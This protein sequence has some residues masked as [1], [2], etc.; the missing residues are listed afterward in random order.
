MNRGGRSGETALALALEA[1]SRHEIPP[2]DLCLTL[3]REYRKIG[4]LAAA[5]RWALAVVDAGDDF[6]AWRSAAA[7]L[8][9]CAA[10]APPPRRTVRIAV[11]GSYT[12]E[13]LVTMLRVAS[14]R[15]GIAADITNGGYAQYRQEILDPTSSL[16]AA[17]PDLVLVATHEGEVG[18]PLLAD[19]PVAA[20][21]SELERWTSLWRAVDRHSAARVVQHNFVVPSGPPWGH[22]SVQLTNSRYAML[23][24]LNAR[25]GSAAAEARGVSIVDCDRIAAEFGKDRWADA[26]YWHLSKQAVSLEAL[27]LLSRHTAAVIAAGLGLSRKCIVLDLDNTLWGGIIGEDGLEGIALGNGPRGE[28]FVAFQD[29]LHALRERGVVLAVVSKN[30]D[31]DAREPFERLPDMRLKLEDIACFAAGWSAKPDSIRAVARQLGLG[32]DALV[33]VDDNPAERQAVR[34]AL[35][36]VDVVPL[37]QDPA[38]YVRALSRYLMLEPS[39]FTAEDADRTRQYQARAEAARLESSA[40]SVE[41]FLA[42]LRMQAI[43]RPFDDIDL[44]RIEQLIGKTN[45]FNLTTRRHG[46][47]Y[48]RAVMADARAIHLTLRLRDRFADHGLVAVLIATPRDGALD[49]D[50]WLM[51]C[52]VIGRTVE[53]ELFRQLLRRAREC[54]YDVLTGTHIPTAKNEL[55]RDLYARLGF[56]RIGEV[57]GATR[58]RYDLA[59]G[60]EPGGRYIEVMDDWHPADDAGAA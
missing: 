46:L 19:D 4:D 50:S 33:F 24:S 20:V 5:W 42:G 57:E 25:L 60:D 8:D 49:I 56:E 39:A 26:R 29:Y 18:L 7:L 15:I 59:R 2:A 1:V 3:A 27:P 34:S 48:L 41:E 47:P 45:Q 22:L 55:V 31:A 23:Q 35:P 37:P 36:E 9:A 43:V 11:A 52:R 28:A 40:E 44:P 32:L 6:T 38:G 16:H 10:G 14:A 53:H 54:G 51:S 30:N 21:E 12:T 13:Q 58:W 17:S